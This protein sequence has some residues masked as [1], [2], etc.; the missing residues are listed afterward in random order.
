MFV[1]WISDLDSPSYFVASAAVD[2][3]FFKREG[4]D[5]ELVHDDSAREGMRDG[6]VHFAAGSTFSPTG[7]FPAWKGLKILCAL[8]QYSYWFLAVRA[9]LDVKRGDMNALKGLRISASD[10]F[11]AIGLQHL[12]E[13]AGLDLARDN[14]RILPPPKSSGSGYRG[15][16][17]ADAITQNFADAFWG[18]GMRVAVAEQLGVAKV[19]LDLRRGDGPP[20]AR[21]YNFPMLATTDKLIAEHPDVAA[22][23]VRAIVNTQKALIADPSLAT[24]VGERLFPGEEASLIAPLI[25]RD[26]PFYDARI[27]P[28]AVD[29]VVK[30]GLRQKLLK[31]PITYNDLIATQFSGLWN[32]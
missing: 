5:V 20:G 22:A 2:L 24:Q 8:A 27:A 31:V 10:G 28:E 3:G 6:R 29:G 11:P 9:D 32:M 7:V 14:I 19:H 21:Y 23:A 12:L 15:R 30:L 13:E 26:A 17:G 18:N 25:A 4:V 1:L 16:R